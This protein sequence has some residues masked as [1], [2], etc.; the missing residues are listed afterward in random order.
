MVNGSKIRD[1]VEEQPKETHEATHSVETLVGGDG[2]V[3]FFNPWDRH[4]EGDKKPKINKFE[5]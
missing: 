3:Y 2:D 5:F 1:S 4:F